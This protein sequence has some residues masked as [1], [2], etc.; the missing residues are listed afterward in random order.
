[1]RRLGR[2]RRG[3]ERHPSLAAPRP[4]PRAA[5]AAAVSI[6]DRFVPRPPP[7]RVSTDDVFGL[8]LSRTAIRRNVTAFA[9]ATRLGVLRTPLRTPLA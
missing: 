9:L 7:P 5:A 4:A 8:A 2:R 6:P 3:V 1:M